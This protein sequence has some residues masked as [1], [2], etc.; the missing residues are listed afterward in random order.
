MEE[1]TPS[2]R[3]GSSSRNRSSRSSRERSTRDV[4]DD[5]ESGS[6]RELRKF[7][8]KL[9]YIEEE[10]AK[11]RRQR[12]SGSDSDEDEEEESGC[13]GRCCGRRR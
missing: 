4:S 13:C 10:L 11:L 8:K 9:S 12:T 2:P 7:K 6:S 1:E 5:L 3:E